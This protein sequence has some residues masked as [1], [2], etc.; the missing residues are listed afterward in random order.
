MLGAALAAAVA[1]VAEWSQSGT[2]P[3]WLGGIAAALTALTGLFRSWQ[4]V[5]LTK[6]E[7]PVVM[8]TL[9][10]DWENEEG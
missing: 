2:A 3:A 8:E 6:A 10:A 7:A 5:S 1:F 9:P 4:S